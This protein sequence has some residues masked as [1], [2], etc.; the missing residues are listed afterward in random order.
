MNLLRFPTIE[1]IEKLIEAAESLHGRAV[2]EIFY[3]TG[4]R[5]REV[6]SMRCGDVEFNDCSIRV[7]GK[8]A[9]PRIVLF[10]RMAER[11]AGGISG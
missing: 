7:I 2:L 5:L 4:C 8:G 1:E 11:G 6:T 9:R 3:A 10:G